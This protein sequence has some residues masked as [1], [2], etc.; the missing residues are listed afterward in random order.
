MKENSATF[1][2]K[3]RKIQTAYN[4]SRIGDRNYIGLYETFGYNI[5]TLDAVEEKL[6]LSVPGRRKDRYLDNSGGLSAN[7]IGFKEYCNPI[8]C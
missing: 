8:S 7:I 6:F 3:Y 2:T 1:V 5:K 4:K